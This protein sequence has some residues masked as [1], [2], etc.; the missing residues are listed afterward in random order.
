VS[1]SISKRAG[2]WTSSTREIP[3]DKA[4]KAIPDDQFLPDPDAA[5]QQIY[6][7]HVLEDVTIRSRSGREL[8]DGNDQ[9]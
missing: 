1:R 3:A 2:F 7:Q 6:E 4:L 9:A 8:R 5:A